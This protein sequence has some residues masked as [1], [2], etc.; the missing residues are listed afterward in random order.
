MRKPYVFSQR[1]E[2]AVGISL[3]GNGQPFPADAKCA[4]ETSNDGISVQ[5]F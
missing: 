4:E 3:F 5:E 1:F 2:T